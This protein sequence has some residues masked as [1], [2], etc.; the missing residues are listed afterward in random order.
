MTATNHKLISLSETNG[1]IIKSERI[2]ESAPYLVHAVPGRVRFRVYR[3]NSDNYYAEILEKVLQSEP[4]VIQV[5]INRAAASVA[6][7]Y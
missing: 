7:Y 4:D 5:R 3:L 6:I 1:A 2:V